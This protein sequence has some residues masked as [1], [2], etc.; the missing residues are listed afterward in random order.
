[1]EKMNIKLAYTSRY[2]SPP[3]KEYDFSDVVKLFN[4]IIYLEELLKMLILVLKL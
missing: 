4:Y 2:M 3:L 1:M